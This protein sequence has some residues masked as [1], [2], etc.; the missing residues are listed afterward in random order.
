MT[1]I[2]YVRNVTQLTDRDHERLMEYYANLLPEE[3]IAVHGLHT[4]VSQKRS[5]QKDNSRTPA[6]YHATFILAVREY[7]IAQNPSAPSRRM[8]MKEAG[9]VDALQKTHRKA[10]ASR[11]PSVVQMLAEQHYCDIKMLRDKQPKPE[12]WRTIAEKMSH[13][14]GHKISHTGLKNIYEKLEE[15]GGPMICQSLP[16]TQY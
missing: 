5:C 1:D 9:Q 2:E 7:K 15:E 16:D 3:R 14:S 4:K 11:K 12:P 13:Q 8:T 6:Y 10:R